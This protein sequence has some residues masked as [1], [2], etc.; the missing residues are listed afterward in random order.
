MAELLA[1]AAEDRRARAIRPA[2]RPLAPAG[3]LLIAFGNA[4]IRAGEHLAGA[5]VGPGVAR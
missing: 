2:P 1:E 3:V 5:S 4:L